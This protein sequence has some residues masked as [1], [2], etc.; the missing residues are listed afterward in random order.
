MLSASVIKLPLVMTLYIDAEA[1]RIDLD[2]RIRVGERVA[3][4]G[5]LSHLPGVADMTARDLAAIAVS[6][7]DNTATNRL[8]ELVG[9]DR[10]NDRLHEW[11]YTGTRLRR[12]MYDLEAKAQGRENRMTARETASL[13]W[14][15]LEGANAGDPAMSSVFLLLTRNSDRSRLGR[16]VPSSVALAHK[17][18]WDT[19][20]LI[21]NDAGIVRASATPPGAAPGPGV[22]AVGLTNGIDTREARSIL[23]LLGLS[24]ADLAGAELGALPSEVPGAP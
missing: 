13:L 7:S 24:A 2:R 4:S 23:G 6:V 10:V 21:D 1:G 11:G 8:I 5:V 16:Y 19:A 15:V 18:G 17:D 20:P 9:I 12:T 22:V 3:G 14:R